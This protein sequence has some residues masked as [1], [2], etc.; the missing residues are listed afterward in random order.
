MND[1]KYIQEE[2]L[3]TFPVEGK[4]LSSFPPY[5][6]LTLGYVK[7]ALPRLRIGLGYAATTTGGRANYT[8]YSGSIHSDIAAT[9]HRVGATVNYRVA[10]SDPLELSVFGRLDVHYSKIEMMNTVYVL[11]LSD[12]VLANY[13]AF[14]PGTSA[15]IE[16]L[17]RLRNLSFGLEGGYMLDIP[18]KLKDKDSGKDWTDPND[19]QNVIT[20]D[21]SG[22]RAGVK[23]YLWID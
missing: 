18:G 22:L 11:G 21:W 23:L 6:Y 2:V 8:D 3:G 4:I 14:S 9:S 5:S 10:G 20:S 12:G 7:Q 17:Y 16:I 15:G 13:R 1:L 19:R